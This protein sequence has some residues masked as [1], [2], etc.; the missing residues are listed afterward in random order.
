MGTNNERATEEAGP[1]KLHSPHDLW[2]PIS[3]EEIQL[4]PGGPRLNPTP[5]LVC[6]ELGVKKTMALQWQVA[7]GW[8]RP[9]FG[10]RGGH[11]FFLNLGLLPSLPGTCKGINCRDLDMSP[12]PPWHFCNSLISPRHAPKNIWIYGNLQYSVHMPLSLVLPHYKLSSH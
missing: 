10:G 2:W 12:L 11:L 5:L 4:L 3:R 8:S 9:H 7:G 6:K 1:S